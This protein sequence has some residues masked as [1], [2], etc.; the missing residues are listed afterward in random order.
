MRARDVMTRS[1][2]AVE[3]ATLVKEA[4]ELL[5]KYGFTTLPVADEDGRLVGVVTEADLLRDRIGV[6]PR[7]LVH[8]DWPVRSGGAPAPTVGAV[9]TT[10]VVFRGPNADAAELARVML[11]KHLRAIPIVDAK[12]LVGIVTR[13]DLLRTIA[14]DDQAITRDVRHHL[15]RCFRRGDWSAAVEASVVTLVDEFGD[16][17]ERHIATVIASAVPGVVDV[18]VVTPAGK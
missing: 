3:P 17:S 5:V 4:A 9:M 12:L 8:P 1:V 15:A 6:D 14:R 13:R 11:D 16:E 7:S 18:K 2:V 10:E